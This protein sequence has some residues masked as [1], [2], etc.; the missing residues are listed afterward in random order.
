[1]FGAMTD[2]LNGKQFLVVAISGGTSSGE[3]VA[4]GR[5]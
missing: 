3:M 1:V 4:Y 2:M 5:P